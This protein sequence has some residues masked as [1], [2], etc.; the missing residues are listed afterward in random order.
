[1]GKIR[2]GKL[3]AIRK[4]YCQYRMQHKQCAM[5]CLIKSLVYWARKELLIIKC[6]TGF[7]HPTKWLPFLSSPRTHKCKE[8]MLKPYSVGNLF[9]RKK[10]LYIQ[11]WKVSLVLKFE[12]PTKKYR[13]LE[14]DTNLLK[15]VKTFRK[16]IRTEFYLQIWST[17]VK[18]TFEFG[19]FFG[20]GV[21]RWWR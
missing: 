15:S 7:I 20:W 16:A 21:H 14:Y 8:Q 19:F 5:C 18:N 13:S 17:V 12:A 4:L 1:M 2:D 3:L 10:K 11:C 6:S 9:T